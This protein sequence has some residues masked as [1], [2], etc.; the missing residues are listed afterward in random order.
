M[1]TEF[2]AWP[3]LCGQENSR[4]FLNRSDAKLE[5]IITVQKVYKAFFNR[6]TKVIQD[7]TGVTLLRSVI[8]GSASFSL[9]HSENALFLQH[10][11]ERFRAYSLVHRLLWCPLPARIIGVSHMG[12]YTKANV[13]VTSDH[14]V[15]TKLFQLF[16]TQE[17]SSTC[18]F[19]WLQ[20]Y[21]HFRS[22]WVI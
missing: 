10:Q 15:M 14:T 21:F 11:S 1:N 17:H 19:K 7:C 8:I 20:L 13:F 5:S 9:S 6:V 18:P 3:S 4:H 16:P 12:T 2:Q 22:T